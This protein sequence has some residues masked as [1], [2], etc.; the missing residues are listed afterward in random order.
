MKMI[1]DYLLYES[2]PQEPNSLSRKF[3]FWPFLSE[4]SDEKRSKC[5]SGTENKNKKDCIKK[6]NMNT[7]KKDKKSDKTNKGGGLEG[8]IGDEIMGIFGSYDY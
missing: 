1:R 5:K 7:S 6:C 8:G 3:F 2:V 4:M